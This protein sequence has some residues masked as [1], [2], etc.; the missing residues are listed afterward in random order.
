MATQCCLG[1]RPAICRLQGRTDFASYES[2][3]KEALTVD[4]SHATPDLKTCLTYFAESS[5][6]IFDKGRENK[7]LLRILGNY[8]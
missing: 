4:S 5:T 7:T 2:N 1:H 8:F 6:D 3:K